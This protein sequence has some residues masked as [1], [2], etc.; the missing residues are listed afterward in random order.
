MSTDLMVYVNYMANWENGTEEQI[1]HLIDEV[2]LF[3][4]LGDFKS[5][6]AVNE[7]F[8]TLITLAEKLRN[9]TIEADA[10]QLSADAAAV[11]SFFSFG[12]SMVA[13][14]GFESI[15]NAMEKNISKD[16]EE[17]NNKMETIDVDISK[18]IDQNV[19]KYITDYK[20][21]NKMISVQ[22]PKALNLEEARANL[23]QFMAQVEK[24]FKDKG[25]LTVANFKLLAASARLAFDS[26]EIK[27]VYDALDD[28]NLSNKSQEDVNKLM[29]ILKGF[30]LPDP[31][32]IALIQGLSI[33]VVNS[34]MNIAKEKIEA[35][36][37]EAGIAVEEYDDTA[38]GMMDAVGKFA[39]G[40]TVVI[41]VANA[42]IEVLDI[43]K[44]VEQ[45][46]E[47]VDKLNDT[48]KPNYLSF[49]NSIKESSKA[50]NKAI[51][52]SSSK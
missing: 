46:K 24:R 25:G 39:L 37:E 21:N 44:V 1:Q 41:S 7:E 51:S 40:V 10:I 27:K 26:E 36:C 50:Y 20:K 35:S 49:F 48:I 47:M 23:M 9:E 17:L 19:Y 11:A 15:H 13:F 22:S 32:A 52:T 28:L 38:F 4:S 45:T 14:L 31:K 33:V 12:L 8:K 3:K 29:D 43:V 18:K 42:I 16:S 5:D 2:T 34:K 30:D 6:S